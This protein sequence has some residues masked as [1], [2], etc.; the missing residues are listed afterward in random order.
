ML[1]NNMWQ[2]VDRDV[3]KVYFQLSKMKKP[4]DNKRCI[5][6]Y[7]LRIKKKKQYKISIVQ[8]SSLL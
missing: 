2:N 6:F 5:I 8:I 4:W 7:S 1:W 3:T